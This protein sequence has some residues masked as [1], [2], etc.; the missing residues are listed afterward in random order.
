MNG[1][2]RKQYANVENNCVTVYRHDCVQPVLIQQARIQR[3]PRKYDD[4]N[5]IGNIHEEHWSET[6]NATMNEF[7]K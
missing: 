4:E 3:K 7:H 1:Q 2:T 5:A 6:K